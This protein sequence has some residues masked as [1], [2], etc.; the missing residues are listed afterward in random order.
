MIILFI[1][2]RLFM[3]ATKYALFQSKSYISIIP[4]LSLN[5]INVLFSFLPIEEK[6]VNEKMI[7]GRCRRNF[8]SK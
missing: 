6:N 1:S 3:S 2:E 7:L 4:I 8:F 5:K